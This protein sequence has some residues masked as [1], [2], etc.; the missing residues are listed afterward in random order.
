M[1]KKKK[2]IIVEGKNLIDFNPPEVQAGV[3]KL[4]TENNQL[5]S[6]KFGISGNMEIDISVDNLDG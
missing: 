3:F 4:L 5:P 2:L 6:P 1:Q